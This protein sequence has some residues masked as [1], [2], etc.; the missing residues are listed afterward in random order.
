MEKKNLCDA[1]KKPFKMKGDK[2]YPLLG[3]TKING[4][5]FHL[6]ICDGCQN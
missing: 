3:I 1:C 2:F 5:H 6:S 4:V